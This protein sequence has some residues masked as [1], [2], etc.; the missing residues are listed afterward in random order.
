M[1]PYNPA[2][3]FEIGEICVHD[4]VF[5]K[6]AIAGTLPTPLQGDPSWVAF[7]QKVLNNR[8]LAS[9]VDANGVVQPF[10]FFDTDD[11]LCIGPQADVRQTIITASP[12]N[13]FRPQ[14]VADFVEA[15]GLGPL[16]AAPATTGSGNYSYSP[17]QLAINTG[18][19]NGSIVDLRLPYVP[20][21]FVRGSRVYF[22]LYTYPNGN[23]DLKFGVRNPINGHYARFERAEDNTASSY[24]AATAD[25]GTSQQVATY[26]GGDSVRTLFCIEQTAAAEFKFY[27][28]TSGGRLQHKATCNLKTPSGMAEPFVR[29]SNRAAANRLVYLDF[30]WSIPI[31]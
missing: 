17:G 10:A 15:N 26:H 4:D 11:A 6:A 7:R 3:D 23:L 20:H 2:Y 5:W 21:T 14:Y 19:T 24:V 1:K 25:G 8:N 27:I 30:V 31:R 28:S 9:G 13:M 18:T 22:Y 16:V 29:F 12:L